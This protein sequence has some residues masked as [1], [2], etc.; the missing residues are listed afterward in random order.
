MGYAERRPPV[1]IP[2]SLQQLHYE[3]KYLPGA[4]NV[5]AD[6]LCWRTTQQ[7]PLWNSRGA[8][9]AGTRPATQRR[10]PPHFMRYSISRDTPETGT[11]YVA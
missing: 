9:P 3:I 2:K 11:V 8:W 5:V 6:A 7:A 1:A 4:A 10:H